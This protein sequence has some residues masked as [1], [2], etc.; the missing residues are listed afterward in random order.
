MLPEGFALAMKE[1]DAATAAV[2]DAAKPH[3]LVGLEASTSAASGAPKHQPSKKKASKDPGRSAVV[4]AAGAVIAAAASAPAPAAADVSAV[5][6]SAV[7]E[8]DSGAGASMLP[9]LTC[10][11]K[12]AKGGS[13]ATKKVMP[14]LIISDLLC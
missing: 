6:A 13:G 5:V 7:M 3:E 9:G 8:N 10:S 2:A 12:N 11:L 1:E 14:A 4:V